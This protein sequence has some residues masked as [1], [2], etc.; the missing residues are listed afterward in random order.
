VHGAAPALLLTATRV[1]VSVVFLAVGVDHLVHHEREAEAF[2]RWGLPFPAAANLATGCAE[3]VLGTML[4]LGV[5]T[6]GAAALLACV[7]VGAIATA[8]RVDGGYQLVVPPLLCAA[9]L[10]LAWFGGGRWQ[11]RPRTAPAA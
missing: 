7:M 1:V 9:C 2:D 4:L 8:G 10:A 5:A 6:R 11:L 3:L